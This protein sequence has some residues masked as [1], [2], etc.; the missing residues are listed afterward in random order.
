MSHRR[1][2]PP[3]CAS[4]HP[5]YFVPFEAAVDFLIEAA[6]DPLVEAAVVKSQG[7]KPVLDLQIAT[8]EKN[9]DAT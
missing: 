4:L 1:A 3:D 7:K 9:P 5:G 6:V 8:A 2:I